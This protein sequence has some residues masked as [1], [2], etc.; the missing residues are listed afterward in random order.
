MA[1]LGNQY[2]VYQ[3]IFIISA[4]VSVT[5]F[6]SQCYQISCLQHVFSLKF[7]N[8]SI[9]SLVSLGLSSPCWLPFVTYKHKRTYPSLH[10]YKHTHTDRIL[11]ILSHGQ[12]TDS[13]NY[14][15]T[16]L[17]ESFFIQYKVK[18]TFPRISVH[19]QH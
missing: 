15:I 4:F 12:T 11:V 18:N 8:S 6:Q 1:T 14:W 10:T 5:K 19:I 17:V 13:L 7:S 3:N 9:C 2:I 16:R